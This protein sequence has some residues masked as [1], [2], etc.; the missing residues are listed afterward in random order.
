MESKRKLLEL[1]NEFC[2]IEGHKKIYNI[3]F[4]TTSKEQPNIKFLVPF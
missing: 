1:I 3:I 4:L 2:K